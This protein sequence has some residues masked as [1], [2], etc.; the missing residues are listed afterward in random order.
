MLFNLQLSFFFSPPRQQ[1]VPYENQTLIGDAVSNITAT[2]S[3]TASEFWQDFSTFVFLSL[4]P[5][6]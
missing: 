4:V 2:A 6:P 5:P 3:E 1:Q